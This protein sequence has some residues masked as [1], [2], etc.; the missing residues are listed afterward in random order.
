MGGVSID[1]PIEAAPGASRDEEGYAKHLVVRA[2]EGKQW[3]CLMPML[4]VSCIGGMISGDGG[5][6]E[7]GRGGGGRAVPGITAEAVCRRDLLPFPPPSYFKI[8]NRS[9]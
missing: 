8:R 6:P 9:C 4:V 7:R 5:A 2:G 3:W 1:G